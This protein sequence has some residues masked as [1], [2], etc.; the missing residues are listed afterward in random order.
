MKKSSYCFILL[1][2]IVILNLF[3]F[4]IPTM[5]LKEKHSIITIEDSTID[6]NN[7]TTNYGGTDD[8]EVGY[9]SNWLEAYIKFTL[10]GAPSS[11]AEVHLRL[12]F[13]QVSATT[14]I[15]IYETSTAW[16][17]YT[18][19]WNNAPSYGTP[20]DSVIVTQNTAY[21]IDITE[22]IRS[23]SGFWSICLT[24]LE[25]NWLRLASRQYPSIYEPPTIIYY[26]KESD[27]SIYMG[28]IIAITVIAVAIIGFL[29]FIFYRRNRFPKEIIKPI[30]PKETS[31]QVIPQTRTGMKY[32]VHCGQENRE[33][34]SFCVACGKEI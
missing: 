6:A 33:D 5:A 26:A 27:A 13:L 11:F 4:S 3:L 9:I 28:I 10:S 14:R 1:S 21:E 24:S 19:T 12:D 7:P 31:S 16:D 15:Y 32:C 2:Y 23:E 22:S 25:T 29:G 30:I 8:L 18:I 17:E 34:Y 20:V